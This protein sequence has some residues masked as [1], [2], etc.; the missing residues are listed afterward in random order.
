MKLQNSRYSN[1]PTD[2]EKFTRKNDQMYGLIAGGY[3]LFVKTLPIWK[4]WICQAL[5]H[6]QGPRVL[7]VL[8]LLKSEMAKTRAGG[9][10]EMLEVLI[11]YRWKEMFG[12]FDR[13]PSTIEWPST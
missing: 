12:G 2:K 4:G 7:E 9:K 1:E 10:S 11:G 5:P 3:D 6:I 13:D 8:A